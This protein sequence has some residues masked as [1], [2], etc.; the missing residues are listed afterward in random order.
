MYLSLIMT[1]SIVSLIKKTSPHLQVK[2]T[3]PVNKPP[4]EFMEFSDLERTV[5]ISATMRYSMTI[6]TDT[7]SRTE[8]GDHR[9]DL[10]VVVDQSGVGMFSLSIPSPQETVDITVSNA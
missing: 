1:C 8:S 10:T 4:P 5:N 9:E 6:K 2:I 7:G 3:D